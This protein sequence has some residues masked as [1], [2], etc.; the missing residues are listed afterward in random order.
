MSTPLQ[1]VMEEPLAVTL[2]VNERGTVRRGRLHPCELHQVCLRTGSSGILC[3]I[4]P[5]GSFGCSEMLLP[6]ESGVESLSNAKL[7]LTLTPAGR[8]SEGAS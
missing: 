8:Q 6:L 3:D 7:G 1:E 4:V 5:A 2:R